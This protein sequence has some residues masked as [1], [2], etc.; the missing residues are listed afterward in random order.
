MNTFLESKI[1]V[2]VDDVWLEDKPGLL[3]G[4][5]TVRSNVDAC[6]I[7]T[8]Y[9]YILRGEISQNLFFFL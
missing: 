3:V 5:E 9:Y 4:E 2:P 6:L 1:G 7:A 8:E